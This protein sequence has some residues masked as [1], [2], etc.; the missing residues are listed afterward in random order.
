MQALQTIF[1]AR[2]D[3]DSRANTAREIE[4]RTKT[5]RGLWHRQ[6]LIFPEV[7]P[8]W[9]PTECVKRREKGYLW[10]SL[11]L[12]HARARRQT[13]KPSSPSRYGVLRYAMLC[14]MHAPCPLIDLA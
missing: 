5:M 8:C 1:V 13:A 6:L 10:S 4:R 11:S 7:G 2:T 12:P 9:N 3:K 14:M